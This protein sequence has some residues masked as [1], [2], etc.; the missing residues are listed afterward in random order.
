M[1]TRPKPIIDVCCNKGNTARSTMHSG[2]KKEKIV[3][4][5]MCVFKGLQEWYLKGLKINIFWNLFLK[6]KIEHH[7]LAHYAMYKSSLIMLA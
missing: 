2:V 6:K 7:F 1:E 5:I 3:K 4:K